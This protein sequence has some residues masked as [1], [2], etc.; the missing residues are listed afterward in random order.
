MLLLLYLLEKKTFGRSRYVVNEKKIQ[1]N[2]TQKVGNQCIFNATSI[3]IDLNIYLLVAFS[4][5]IIWLKLV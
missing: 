4:K 3:V 2:G 1:Q 5:E